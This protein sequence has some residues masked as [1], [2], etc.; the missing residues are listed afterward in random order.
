MAQVLVG[1][2]GEGGG[3][4]DAGVVH[5]DVDRPGFVLHVTDEGGDLLRVQEVGGMGG[6]PKLG[7]QR[8]NGVFAPGDECHNGPGTREGA[9]EGLADSPRCPCDQHAFSP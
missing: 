5:Q 6:A 9:G 1:R 4:P 2:V 7:R 3:A 8:L